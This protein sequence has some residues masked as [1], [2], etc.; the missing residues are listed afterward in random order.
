MACCCWR[1]SMSPALRSPASATAK[2]SLPP[3]SSAASGSSTATQP[4]DRRTALCERVEIVEQRRDAPAVPLIHDGARAAGRGDDVHR[5]DAL[6]DAR[7]V[8]GGHRELAHAE[9]DEKRG[10][11]RI[12]R[13]LAA[14]A[15][16][17]AGAVGRLDGELD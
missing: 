11:T 10:E 9:A 17:D 5:A 6:L 13:H 8:G 16:R 14:D 12:A 3:W 7:D 15:D 1:V 2:I 4:S